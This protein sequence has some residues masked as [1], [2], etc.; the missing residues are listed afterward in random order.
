VEIG[1]PAPRE[2]VRAESEVAAR[3]QD[4]IVAQTSYQQQQELLKTAISKH[5]DADLAAVQVD[6]TDKLPEPAENDI[7]PLQTA[8]AEAI[9]NRPEVEQA[10]LNIRNADYTIHSTRSGLLPLLNVF[11]TYPASGL[12]GNRLACLSGHSPAGG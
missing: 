12:G 3:Q 8:L 6:A 10:G 7:P 1:T 4:L 11:A 2:V 5:V 9:K